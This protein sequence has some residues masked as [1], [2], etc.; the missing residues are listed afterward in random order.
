VSAGG[1]F[2]GHSKQ[3]SLRGGQLQRRARGD[4]ISAREAAASHWPRFQVLE[5]PNLQDVTSHLSCLTI[6]ARCQQRA[7]LPCLYRR[8]I[9]CFFLG[10]QLREH[11]PVDIVFGFSKMPFEDDQFFAV[12]EFFHSV[13]LSKG[14]RGWVGDFRPQPTSCIRYH[15]V[16]FSDRNVNGR[17]GP[18]RTLSEPLALSPPQGCE[19]HVESIN[20]A[21]SLIGRMHINGGRE[22]G[23]L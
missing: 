12:Y 22:H 1:R 11:L 10:Q 17:I 23:G 5:T 18:H 16:G 19:G 21:A 4:T 7:D 3:I 15:Q 2:G 20:E 6:E 9:P 8:H 14:A 13:L